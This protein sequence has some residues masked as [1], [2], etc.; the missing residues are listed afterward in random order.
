V[1]AYFPFGA[2]PRACIGRQLAIVESKLIL[3]MVL[4]EWDVEVLDDEV[5]RR[6]AITMQPT[7]PVS[8]V[9]RRR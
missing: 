6:A 4:A 1:P 2:G 5:P 9:A 3:A 7:G 8:A